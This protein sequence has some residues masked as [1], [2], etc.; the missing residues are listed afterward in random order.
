MPKSLGARRKAS[1][2]RIRFVKEMFMR[3]RSLSA[4]ACLAI[5]SACGRAAEPR[6]KAGEADSTGSTGTQVDLR[7]IV[8]SAPKLPLQAVELKAQP[9]RKGWQLG[10]VSWIAVD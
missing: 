3:A 10:A 4:I 2:Q 5:V 7:Q 8:R 9:P 6:T 1:R